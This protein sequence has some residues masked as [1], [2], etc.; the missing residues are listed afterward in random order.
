MRIWYEA[1]VAADGTPVSATG[2]DLGFGGIGY[3]IAIDALGNAIV[4]P[5]GATSYAT[6]VDGSTGAVTSPSGELT[7]PAAL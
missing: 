5:I 3:P 2:Y 1:G 6:K 7:P 4:P